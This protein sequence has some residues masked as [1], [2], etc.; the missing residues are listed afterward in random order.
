MTHWTVPTSTLK[1][2]SIAGSATFSAVKSLAI[3]I[4]PRP[5]A[6]SAITVPGAIRSASAW[7]LAGA[8]ARAGDRRVAV[9]R[10][11]ERHRRP[12]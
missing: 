9:V 12:L 4:T 5:I 11:P 6:T 1:S 2:C 7:T 3:T 10:S 8:A